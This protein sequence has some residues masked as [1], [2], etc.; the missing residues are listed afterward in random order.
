MRA[1]YPSYITR[2]QFELI[3]NTLESSK[4]VT[5]PRNID[6]YDIFCA[7]LYRKREG[8]RWRCLPHDFPKW[9]NCYY[10]YN[11][12][13]KSEEVEESVLDRV[14]RE[15]VESER[16]V[17]GRQSKQTTMAYPQNF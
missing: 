17:H 11:E 1:S 7:I 2:N 5:Q 13:R 14:M 15:L 9:Q 10:H 6:I 3:R 16:I 12:W 8:C 4:K